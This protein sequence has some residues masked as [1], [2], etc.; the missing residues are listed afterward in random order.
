MGFY[1][2]LYSII[3]T[4][5]IKPKL[6]G[7]KG[8]IHLKCKARKSVKERTEIIIETN[9]SLNVHI[10]YGTESYIINYNK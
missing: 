9:L 3:V 1:N 8:M 7:I 4:L 2:K 6:I 5:S 10:R